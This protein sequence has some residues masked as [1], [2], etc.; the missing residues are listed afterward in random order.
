[1]LEIKN[2]SPADQSAIEN[3]LDLSFGSSRKKKSAYALRAGK[4]PVPGLS[5]V[6]RNDGNLVG[7]IQFWPLSLDLTDGEIAGKG[8]LLLGPLAVHPDKQNLGIGRAL[9][10]EG[11]NRASAAGYAAAILVGDPAYYSKFGFG[12]ECVSGLELSLES[13]QARVQGR[14]LVKDALSRLKGNIFST[15]NADE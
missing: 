9:I 10:E 1:M 12:H 14:E 8:V 11:M 6:A 2:Q 4:Q 7:S 3:L 15:G 5:L 13:D